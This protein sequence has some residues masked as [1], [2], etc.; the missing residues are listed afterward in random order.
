MFFTAAY[1]F[2]MYLFYTEITMY[3]GEVQPITGHESPEVE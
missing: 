2:G 1:I 3:K